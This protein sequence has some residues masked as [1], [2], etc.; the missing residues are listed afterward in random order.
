[1][2]TAKKT[3]NCKRGFTCGRACISKSKT[4]RSNLNAKGEKVVETFAEFVKRVAAEQA[5][6]QDSAPKSLSDFAKPKNDLIGKLREGASEADWLDWQDRAEQAGQGNWEGSGHE[7]ANGVS[8]V[9]T[10]VTDQSITDKIKEAG[11]TLSDQEIKDGSEAIQS[12]SRSEFARMRDHEINGGGDETTAQAVVDANKL[13]A[14]LPTVDAPLYRAL[15]I[16]GDQVESFLETVRQGDLDVPAMS[17]FTTE[18][19]AALEFASGDADLQVLMRIDDNKSGKS[20]APL[21]ARASEFEAIVPKGVRHSITGV[22]Y[23]EEN[24]LIYVEA[25]EA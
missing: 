14:E 24:G 1:M 25:T 12:F 11:V 5:T 2:V 10:L 8:S 13:L 20:V 22:D 16:N 19:N 18:L 23:D 21:S 9:L 4:C 7:W 15:S 3:K 17:S 6:A